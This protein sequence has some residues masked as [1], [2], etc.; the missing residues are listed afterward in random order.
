MKV[1]KAPSNYRGVKWRYGQWQTKIKV[2]GQIQV[3]GPYDTEEGAARAYDEKA[4]QLHANPILNFLPDGSINPDRRKH[5]RTTPAAIRSPGGTAVP[6]T[7]QARAGRYLQEEETGGQAGGGGGGG[8]G[9]S[10][11]S[12]L[13]R[14]QVAKEEVNGEQME[15]GSGRWRPWKRGRWGHEGEEDEATVGIKK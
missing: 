9:R 15:D 4:K 5:T 10:S 2:N 14:G 7:P 1:S 12:S 6:L 13:R 11:S 8:G 3:L